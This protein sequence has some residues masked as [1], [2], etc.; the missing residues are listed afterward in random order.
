[1]DMAL[2]SKSF[3]PSSATAEQPISKSDKAVANDSSSK[4][5]YLNPKAN[6]TRTVPVRLQHEN[7]GIASP[8]MI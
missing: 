2:A 8:I 4:D 1:M 3:P 7:H 6:D 5:T